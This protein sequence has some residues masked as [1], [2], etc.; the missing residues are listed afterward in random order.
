MHAPRYAYKKR[1]VEATASLR[2][3]ETTFHWHPSISTLL[4][5][6]I[7][8]WRDLFLLFC[9]R[10][11]MKGCRSWSFILIY[12]I[13]PWYLPLRLI[14][15]TLKSFTMCKIVWTAVRTSSSLEMNNLSTIENKVKV[16]VTERV[17]IA[18][19]VK[20]SNTASISST[21]TALHL[22]E[23]RFTKGPRNKEPVW[24]WPGRDWNMNSCDEERESKRYE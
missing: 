19:S 4:D 21:W 11:C 1:G 13:L 16:P 18:S 15:I 17:T 10:R 6:I 5:G 24:T 3:H 22:G 14:V 9:H 8:G 12:L 2:K 23:G 7:L 20:D